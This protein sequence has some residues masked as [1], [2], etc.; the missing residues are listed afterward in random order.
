MYLK[1]TADGAAIRTYAGAG[2]FVYSVDVSGDGK[3]IVAGSQ[4]GVLR[5]W[6][7]AGPLIADFPPVTRDAAH[8]CRLPLATAARGQ[9]P[10]S[11]C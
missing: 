10:R 2:D 3:T 4:D 6:S 11:G 9:Q 8:V 5:V 7:E 1:Q